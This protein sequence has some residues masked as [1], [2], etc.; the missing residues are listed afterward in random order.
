MSDP[1]NQ[2]V[3]P[4]QVSEMPKIDGWKWLLNHSRRDSVIA[5]VTSVE[6][7][8]TTSTWPTEDEDY[9]RIIL[10]REVQ[11]CRRSGSS[12]RDIAKSVNRS[13]EW[14]RQS[15]E[16]YSDFDERK[17]HV[18][19]GV[20]LKEIARQVITPV[21]LE[22]YDSRELN[23]SDI[24]NLLGPKVGNRHALYWVGRMKTIH[25]KLK[26]GLPE[27]ESTPVKV[28][29][30]FASNLR[31]RYGITR[32][33]YERMLAA[34][35]GK[36]VICGSTERLHLDHCHRSNQVR[37][38]LCRGCNMALGHVKEDVEILRRAIDYLEKYKSGS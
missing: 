19:P 31:S 29:D 2:D 32:E 15:I 22:K 11:L 23:L 1:R 25:D 13:R 34:Q 3:D 21:I 18:A 27:R 36:C 9:E 35:D 37:G 38:I 30:R 8:E 4:S 17:F 7:Q 16:V 24:R 10:D 26:R 5:F 14:V 28:R 20:K 6:D 12:L 33:D